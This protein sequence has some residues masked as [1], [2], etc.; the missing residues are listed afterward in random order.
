MKT[1]KQHKSVYFILHYNSQKR[2]IC[3]LII[4]TVNINMLQGE[5]RNKS[6]MQKL[7]LHKTF[8]NQQN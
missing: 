3:P 5:M 6:Q 7:Y 8:F 4:Y 1:Q 2:Q